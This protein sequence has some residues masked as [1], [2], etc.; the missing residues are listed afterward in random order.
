MTDSKKLDLILEKVT[1]LEN[2]V[3]ELK[4][5]VTVLKKM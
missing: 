3:T 5:G 1:G 4:E 2:D